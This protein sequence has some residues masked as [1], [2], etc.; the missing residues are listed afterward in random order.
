MYPDQGMC[1]VFLFHPCYEVRVMLLKPLN[2]VPLSSSPAVI[3]VEPSAGTATA[4]IQKLQEMSKLQG[5]EDNQVRGNHFAGLRA[6]IC[7]SDV[8]RTAFLPE[9]VN[10]LNDGNPNAWS[11]RVLETESLRSVLDALPADYLIRVVDYFL[12]NIT[13]TQLEEINNLIRTEVWPDKDV[14]KNQ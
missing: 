7:L 5:E 12:D 10:F 4:F 8:E 14:P 9:F 11:I 1:G 6:L 2:R 3:L 13:A